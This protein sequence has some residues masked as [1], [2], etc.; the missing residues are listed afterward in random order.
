M[1]DL[2]LRAL[3][4][5]L[6]AHPDEPPFANIFDSLRELFT[7]DHALLLEYGETTVHCLAAIPDALVQLQ[8]TPGS[9]LVGPA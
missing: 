8:W 2:P 9:R 6:D 3:E 7:F 4:A 1:G 5:L